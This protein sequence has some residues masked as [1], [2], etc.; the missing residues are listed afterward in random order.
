[1]RDKRATRVE[2]MVEFLNTNPGFYRPVTVAHRMGLTTHQASVTLNYLHAL[3]RIDKTS[4]PANSNG[5][6]ITHYGVT[7]A[8][9][10]TQNPRR[11]FYA[12]QREDVSDAS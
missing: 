10:E 2:D 7:G 9:R 6:F 12:A 3:G 5:R 4:I 11:N 8:V 1:M